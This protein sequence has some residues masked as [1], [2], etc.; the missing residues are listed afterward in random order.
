MIF[1]FFISPKSTIQ[2][3]MDHIDKVHGLGLVAIDE[4]Q[5]LVG[6]LTDGDIRRALASGKLVTD[7][8]KSIVH[9]NPIVAQKSTTQE[10]L[11]AITA[12]RKIKVVPILDGR[13]VIDVYSVD[14][15]ET[16]SI[17]VVIMAGGL[18]SRL[19]EHT[20]DCPKPMI[21]V[22]GQPVLERIIKNFTKVGFQDFYISTNYKAEVIE[23]YFKDGSD[24]NCNISYLREPK[25]LGTAG[26]LSL[27]PDYLKGPIVITN[28]D[29]LTLVDFRRL[30]SFHREHKSPITICTRKYDIQ[31]PFGVVDIQNGQVNAIDE[32]PIHSFNVSAGVY[33]LNLE[34][35]KYIP[36]NEYF[37]MP[38]FFNVLLKENIKADCFPMVEQ[39]IDIGQVSD[40][41]YARSVYENTK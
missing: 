34:L 4:D 25:R 2:E 39:W 19:G 26:S 17:S 10:E 15:E 31:V 22:G 11:K 14:D 7:L 9:A 41:D 8:V 29:L 27:L 20:R 23:Q 24:F 5:N 18:G 16:K 30:I 37:D 3:A 35:L 33:V 21:D 1:N 13:K 38:T 12:N 32:K 6:T 40:L 28:G 36:K